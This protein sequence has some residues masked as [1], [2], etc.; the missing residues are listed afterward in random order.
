MRCRLGLDDTDHPEVGCTTESMNDL[1]VRISREISSTIEER[2]L[3]RLWPFAERRTRGN[4][5]LGAIL[6]FPE[7]EKENLEAVCREWFS[8]LLQRI[9][10]YPPS[11]IPPSPC[12]VLSFDPLPEKWYWEAVRGFVDSFSRFDQATKNKCIVF[13]SN[14]TFGVV[15]ACAAAAWNPSV[16]SSWELI[17]WRQEELVGTDRM[18]AQKAVSGM[19]NNHPETFL[20]RDPTKDRGMIA[21]RTPCPVLYGIRGFS[22][23]VVYNAHQWLQARSDVEECASFASHLTNQLSDDHIESTKRGTVTTTATETR[24]GHAFVFAFTGISSLKLVAF[25]EGGPVNRLLRNL[26]PGDSISWSGLTAPDGS[27]HLE[28]LRLDTSSPRIVGRPSCCSRAMRSAGKGQ[29]L[30]C[31]TCGKTEKKYWKSTVDDLPSGQPTGVWLE[32]TPSNRRH[33]SKP[34][35]HGNPGGT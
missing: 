11:P 31:L 29:D 5:A 16:E 7:H 32:P 24:G 2:R 1:L 22:E 27:V 8:Q 33:L 25:S 15:G 34:L 6:E 20:N 14:S 10:T 4:G 17:S 12:L 28:K 30:R 35:S 23:S 26:R 13:H 9:K 21:P 3:V 18:V 19:E